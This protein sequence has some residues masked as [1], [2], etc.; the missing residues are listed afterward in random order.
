MHLGPRI[1]C[2]QALL[3]CVPENHF[4]VSCALEREGVDSRL[5]PSIV[6]RAMNF[7]RAEVGGGSG[8]GEG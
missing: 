2:D 7:S 4:P 1:A 8:R 3:L 5:G 6:P